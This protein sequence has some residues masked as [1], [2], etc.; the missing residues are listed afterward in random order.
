MLLYLTLT[1]F[2]FAASLGRA[3]RLLGKEGYVHARNQRA[4]AIRVSCQIK[5]NFWAS[6]SDSVN[7]KSVLVQVLV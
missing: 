5:W 6:L 2:H 4:E 7:A 1:V 3:L